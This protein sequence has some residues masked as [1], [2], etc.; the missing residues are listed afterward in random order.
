MTFMLR[1]TLSCRWEQ[2]LFR[3]HG[4]QPWNCRLPGQGDYGL[5]LQA[6]NFKALDAG[7]VD[8]GLKSGI[9]FQAAGKP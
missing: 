5:L 4:R 9:F 3:P 6:V 1:S 7:G 2:F 8:D